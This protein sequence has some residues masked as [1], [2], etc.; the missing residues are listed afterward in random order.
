[1]C[2]LVCQN[3]N[4]SKCGPCGILERG[5][6]SQGRASYIQ[7]AFTEPQFFYRRRR[8]ERIHFSF[9]SRGLLWL[10]RAFSA[11]LTGGKIRDGYGEDG[12][13]RKGLVLRGK[14]QPSIRLIFDMR[15]VLIPRCDGVG[16]PLK[17]TTPPDQAA[18]RLEPRTSRMQSGALC[19][20]PRCPVE[21]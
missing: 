19:A 14:Y 13:G 5:R 8:Q 21:E 18:P 10:S 15:H 17:K 3:S 16:K 11:T 12:C 2:Q 7:I 20:W 4:G 9:P 6:S 1:V